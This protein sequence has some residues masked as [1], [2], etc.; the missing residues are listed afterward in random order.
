MT[1]AAQAFYGT[2]TLQHATREQV[3]AGQ[4]IKINPALVT[5]TDGLIEQVDPQ[6]LQQQV[7][8]QVVEL[9]AHKI[10]TF[11]VDL[12]FD[13]YTGFGQARPQSNL[14][15]FTPAFLERLSLLIASSGGFLNLHLL[16]DFPK[17]H[18]AEWASLPPGAICFQ[19]EVV[20]ERRQL[21]QLVSQIEAMGACASPVI[22]TV[23]S[24]HLH[25]LPPQQV[26]SHLSPLLPALGMLTFQAAGTASR[27]NRP[28]GHFAGAAL[29]SYLALLP[30][31]FTGTLQL[32][33]GITKETIGRAVQMGAEFLVCGTQLFRN[34]EG[35]SAQ[36]IIDMLLAEAARA[37]H[38][39]TTR[40]ATC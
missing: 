5:L 28:S 9:L 20:K 30:D 7:W 25:P 36:A 22:E 17:L 14:A 27:S 29:A 38:G 4:V 2:S 10:R 19:L 39:G 37:L 16:T 18:L 13:D 8:E 31:S 35:P 23:G 3:F 33:G 26:L 40:G 34:R 1:T 24:E 12:N 32:Q 6:T 21:E 11:H 15:V